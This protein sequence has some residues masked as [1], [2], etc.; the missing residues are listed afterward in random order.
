[1]LKLTKKQKI[2]IIIII[3]LLFLI[4]FLPL[5]FLKIK[6]NSSPQFPQSPQITQYSMQNTIPQSTEIVKTD[7]YNN[8]STISD[9]VILNE[10][11]KT[12]YNTD[13]N[14][15]TPDIKNVINVD[16]NKL[17]PM[18]NNFTNT[19]P[20]GFVIIIK[21]N[22]IYHNYYFTVTKID[23][24][25]NLLYFNP[26]PDFNLSSSEAWYLTIYQT[27]GPQPSVINK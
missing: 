19:S 8:N 11:K 1:M 18:W 15:N 14:N 6:T 12:I 4:I 3:I 2:I 23:V 21:Q 13:I 5:Y 20:W 22:T 9:F 7:I 17:T 24:K 25:N 16:L 27:Y 26:P 10:N